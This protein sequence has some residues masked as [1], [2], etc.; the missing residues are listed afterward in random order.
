VSNH[1]GCLRRRG[2]VTPRRARREIIYRITDA[3]LLATL[4][5]ARELIRNHEPQIE[6]C[7]TVSGAS[8][9][10]GRRSH[11]CT[12]AFSR[13]RGRRDWPGAENGSALGPSATR[14]QVSLRGQHRR[15]FDGPS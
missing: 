14:C 1:L 8:S 7:Q 10:H 9:D 13:H 15:W 5:L 2:L 6:A 11:D 12:V 4:A 3:R